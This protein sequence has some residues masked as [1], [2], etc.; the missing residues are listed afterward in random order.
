MKK[1]TPDVQKIKGKAVALLSNQSSCGGA[2][3][4]TKT[5][6]EEISA[7]AVILAS[8][9]FSS[10]YS[11]STNPPEIIGDGMLMAFQAGAELMDL[12]FVQFHPT[13]FKNFLISEA[14]RGEGA[15]LV[16]DEGTQFMKK[17]DSNE[18][19]ARD[20]VARAI[21]DQLSDGKKVFLD[22]TGLEKNFLKERFSHIYEKCLEM[23]VDLTEEPVPVEPAAHY[24]MGGVKTDLKAR[25]RVKGLLACGEVACTG[26][27]G[28]NR[29]ASNSLLSA[30]VFGARAGLQAGKQ[31]PER[32][33]ESTPLLSRKI[34]PELKE[35]F[36]EHAG[37]V[38]SKKFL[39]DRL[40]KLG[41]RD[42]LMELVMKKALERQESRGAHYR[43]DFS[44]K[45]RDAIHS[46]AALPLKQKNKAQR[47][48][49]FGGS[50]NP[51]HNGHLAVVKCLLPE[52]DEVW[53]VPCYKHAFGKNL[54][55][56]E[57]RLEMARLAVKKLDK[58]KVSDVEVKKKQTSYTVDTLEQLNKE[59]PNKRFY[60][61]INANALP[62]F[63][64]WRES[65]RLK[66]DYEFIVVSRQ[67]IKTEFG[68]LL[69][70]DSPKVSGTVVRNLL[71]KGKSVKKF[72]PRQVE[73]YIRENCLYEN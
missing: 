1:Q 43:G 54:V 34:T 16:N 36:W 22:A 44:Q 21:Q 52:F 2:F 70:C 4:Q 18:L 58:V 68:R 62:S 51:F 30:L 9:G 10:L 47:I 13:A 25:T 50:F 28:S 32:V 27:D 33:R 53:V 46:I 8:G 40:E 5:G 56:A 73:D 3:V 45:N 12:E 11:H 35:L 19:S 24:C 42:E 49:V 63:D 72:V 66:R 61:V 55:P 69:V 31:K 20:V 67:P 41:A 60:W 23:G 57:H 65:E 15:K 38:R 39:E 64:F 29:L 59:F 6:T 7:S 14:L 37:I 26:V 48:A 71:K 17:L